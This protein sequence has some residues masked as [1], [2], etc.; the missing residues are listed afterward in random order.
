MNELDASLINIG[1]TECKD[2]IFRLSVAPAQTTDFRLYDD[3]I[4][5]IVRGCVGVRG[6]EMVRGND[7]CTAVH[8]R[9]AW[10]SSYQLEW[11]VINLYTAYCREHGKTL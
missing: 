7:R 4:E 1:L 9:Q 10:S 11:T 5:Q 3:V 2:R 6:Q 8:D